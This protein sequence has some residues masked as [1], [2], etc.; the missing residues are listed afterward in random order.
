M[1]N[2]FIIY[3]ITNSIDIYLMLFLFGVYCKE[4]RH[5][6]ITPRMITSV[7]EPTVQTQ[8]SFRNMSEKDLVLH[9]IGQKAV[10]LESFEVQVAL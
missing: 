2:L 5:N 1:L 8:I 10:T 7:W 4:Q 6:N 9:D 3:L